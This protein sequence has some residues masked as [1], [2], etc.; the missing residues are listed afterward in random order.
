[1]KL[2]EIIATVHRIVDAVDFSEEIQQ[3]NLS[4][5]HKLYLQSKAKPY[6]YRAA[7]VKVLGAKNVVEVGTKTGCGALALAKYAARVVTCDIT[8]ANIQDW[9]I[10]STNIEGRELASPEACLSLDYHNFDFV[11]IDIDHQGDME[12]KIHQKLQATYKGIVMYD[13]IHYNDQMKTFWSNVPNEK[14]E[15]PWHSPYGVGLVRY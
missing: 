12:Y 10:F 5:E 1:M 8:M 7:L 9:K 14:A 15:T 3:F 6:R 2:Q 4:P 13:D 11:F